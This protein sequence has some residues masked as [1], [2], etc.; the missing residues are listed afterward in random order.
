MWPKARIK[1]DVILKNDVLSISARQGP[2]GTRHLFCL[3]RVREHEAYHCY[4]MICSLE[5]FC[6]QTI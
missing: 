3:E 1:Q 6:T 4:E 5:C 2:H